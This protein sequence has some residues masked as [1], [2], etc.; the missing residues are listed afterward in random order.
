M[1]FC[2]LTISYFRLS[3]RNCIEI[4]N[5]LTQIKQLEVFYTTDGKEY[6][7]PQH[8]VKEI[9]DELFVHN[10]RINL[11]ELAKLLSLDFSI[12][13]SKASDIEKTNSSISIVNGQLI[14]NSYLHNICDEIN[15]KLKIKGKVTIADLTSQYDLPSDFLVSVVEKQLGK[16][17]NAEQDTHDRHI[18]FTSDYKKKNINLVRG[19]FLALTKPIQVSTVLGMCNIEEHLFQSKYTG[20]LLT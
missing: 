14:D 10:G 16:L 13:S 17:I 11:V 2:L 8:L 12:V 4:I 5:K 15:E 19:A 6:I 20:N 9:K 3:E 18:F 7:T 1:S